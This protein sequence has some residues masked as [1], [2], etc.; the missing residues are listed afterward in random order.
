[1]SRKEP[2]LTTCVICGKSFLTKTLARKYCSEK[3]R[4]VS[5]K[6]QSHVI[7]KVCEFCE[8]EYQTIYHRSKYCSDECREHSGKG[9]SWY[10]NVCFCCGKRISPHKAFCKEC[11]DRELKAERT[12][13]YKFCDD[14]KRSC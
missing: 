1:M 4:P 6:N 12:Y 11:W 14:T 10:V 9:K 2:V 13:D 3:C 8:N 7:T 5:E